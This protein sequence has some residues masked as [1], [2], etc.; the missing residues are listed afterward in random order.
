M[1]EHEEVFLL[2]DRRPEINGTPN[3]DH[4]AVLKGDEMRQLCGNKIARENSE[5]IVP[6]D[7]TF[8]GVVG[9]VM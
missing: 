6:T 3:K 9:Y 8:I 2:E 7:S 5:T 4:L 1:E